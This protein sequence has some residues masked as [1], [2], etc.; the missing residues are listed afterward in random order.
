MGARRL[1][2]D[3]IGQLFQAGDRS[4]QM[5]RALVCSGRLV[6]STTA[7]G[8]I[9]TNNGAVS[10]GNVSSNPAAKSVPPSSNVIAVELDR[11]P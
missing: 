4:G 8:R 2:S 9:A 5:L 11:T 10:A 3:P 7:L 6:C 1:H